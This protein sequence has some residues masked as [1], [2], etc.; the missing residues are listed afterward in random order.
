MSK[1]YRGSQQAASAAVADT[2][3][4]SSCNLVGKCNNLLVYYTWGSI[5]LNPLSN[6][7]LHTSSQISARYTKRQKSKCNRVRFFSLSSCAHHDN[8]L[9]I[10]YALRSRNI[11]KVSK[12]LERDWLGKENKYSLERSVTRFPSQFWNTESRRGSDFEITLKLNFSSTWGI[13]FKCA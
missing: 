11:C 10:V 3:F 2:Y 9:K 8:L 6:Y 13:F 5:I 12:S 1:V 4:P 7:H